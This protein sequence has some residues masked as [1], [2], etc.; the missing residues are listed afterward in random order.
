M[1]DLHRRNGHRIRRRFM[2]VICAIVNDNPEGQLLTLTYDSAKTSRPCRSCWYRPFYCFYW[3]CLIFS[4][5]WR[6]HNDGR[7]KSES[8]ND[9]QALESA[10]FKDINNVENAKKRA[11]QAKK[12]PA[13][14]WKEISS[15]SR[16]IDYYWFYSYY[17]VHRTLSGFRDLWWGANDRGIHFAAGPD[18]MHLML[19]GLGKHI[20]VYITAILKATGLLYLNDI[21]WYYMILYDII[22]YY[23]ILYDII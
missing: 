19:E 10:H 20:L 8:L 13:A 21:I 11:S 12:R 16:K 3:F 18:W 9:P 15:E 4:Y 1:N 2:P 5:L 6:L 14:A 23:M 22:W 17:S 7:V